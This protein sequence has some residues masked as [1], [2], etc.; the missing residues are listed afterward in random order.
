MSDHRH[1]PNLRLVEARSP[2]P[3]E[4]PGVLRESTRVC[5]I[6]GI[7]DSKTGLIA[8]LPRARPEPEK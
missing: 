4:D 7:I 6:V 2:H 5:R 1:G 3:L 8:D